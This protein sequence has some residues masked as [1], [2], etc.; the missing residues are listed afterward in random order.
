MMTDQEQ[1]RPQRKV[2][3]LIAPSPVVV[4]AEIPLADV[5]ATLDHFDVSG[6]PV[7]DR[8]GRVVGVIR[9]LDIDRLRGGSLATSD[10]RDLLARDLM[11][12]PAIAIPESGSLLEAARLMTEHGVHLLVV[13][14]EHDGRPIGVISTSDVARG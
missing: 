4:Q 5:A 9:G 13:V 7:V 10:W 8:G 6:V 11:T 2:G 3:D 12:Y 14:A 1:H